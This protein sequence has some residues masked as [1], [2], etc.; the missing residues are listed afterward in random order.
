MLDAFAQVAVADALLA[1]ISDGLDAGLVKHRQ[2][3]TLKGRRIAEHVAPVRLDAY[4]GCPKRTLADRLV[5]ELA[6][7]GFRVVSDDVDS[8]SKKRV[9]ESSSQKRKRK[10]SRKRRGAK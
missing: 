3:A 8:E 2:A 4:P 5:S 6:F 10:P 9:I 1:V 7:R